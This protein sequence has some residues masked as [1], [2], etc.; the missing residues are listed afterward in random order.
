MLKSS[1]FK[2]GTFGLCFIA[3]QGLGGEDLTYLKSEVSADKM[4]EHFL[5][6][7]V[8]YTPFE[9]IQKLISKP[10]EV[11]V[12]YHLNEEQILWAKALVN[13]IIAESEVLEVN[14]KEVR[15]YL[16]SNGLEIPMHSTKAMRVVS[17]NHAS[18]NDRQF[19]ALIANTS[20]KVVCRQAELPEP[21]RQGNVRRQT[22]L[23][24]EEGV[25]EVRLSQYDLM[26]I[27]ARMVHAFGMPSN[28]DLILFP[29]KQWMPMLEGSSR[30]LIPKNWDD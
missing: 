18:G 16:L 13:R 8:E 4:L 6:D 9:A 17:G 22:F 7:C 29:D 11:G 28:A 24:D 19:L 10:L 2:F 15:G 25:H 27:P 1:I 14:G 21:L 26:W 5:Q 3:I 20:E 23:D 12:V 30:E